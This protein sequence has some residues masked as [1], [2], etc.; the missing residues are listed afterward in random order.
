MDC[1]VVQ[2]IR[3]Y[4]GTGGTCPPRQSETTEQ[5]EPTACKEESK[6]TAH[7]RSDVELGLGVIIY[8]VEYLN[9]PALGVDN[10]KAVSCYV[11]PDAG[12]QCELCF[13]LECLHASS[14]FYNVGAGL[15][16]SLLP[17]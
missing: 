17:H 15:D 6:T 5:S 16:V 14:S 10:V 11:E 1:D 9:T 13:G 4:G 7:L 8:L 12:G 3:E 2:N